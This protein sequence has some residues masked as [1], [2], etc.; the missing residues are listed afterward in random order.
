MLRDKDISYVVIC[1]NIGSLN[2]TEAYNNMMHGHLP[3]LS[4]IINV[5]SST[6]NHPVSLCNINPTVSRQT[7]ERFGEVYRYKT[8]S[9]GKS[10]ETVSEETMEQFQ[11]YM[12][13]LNIDGVKLT[14]DYLAQIWVDPTSA[15]KIPIEVT[16]IKDIQIM[17][18]SIAISP[19]FD[20]KD[21][22]IVNKQPAIAWDIDIAKIAEIA[23]QMTDILPFGMN[24][25][26]DP[27]TEEEIEP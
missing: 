3:T 4:A 11:S 25:R 26:L 16:S 2:I 24:P 19:S 14:P 27:P 13:S 7:Q 5:V 9:S 1:P 8:S 17:E 22:I 15:D 18:T 21:F 12:D 10:A 23:M 6:I 20:F